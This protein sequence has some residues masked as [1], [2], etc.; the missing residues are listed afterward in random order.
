MEIFKVKYLRDLGEYN[1]QKWIDYNYYKNKADAEWA[2]KLIEGGERIVVVELE[3]IT[4]S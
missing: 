3:V 2:V 1:G 4:V